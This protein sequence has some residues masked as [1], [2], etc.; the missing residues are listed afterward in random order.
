MLFTALGIAIAYF[1]AFGMDFVGGAIAWRL[2]IAMQIVPAI[3]ISI[4]LLGLPETPRWLIEK[5]RVDEAV[6]VMCK[7]YGTTEDDDYIVMEKR[8]II[9][10]L[11]LERKSPFSWLNV[12]KKDQIQTGK[13]VLLACLGL[14]F[15][16]VRDLQARDFLPI[17]KTNRV[18][19]GLA[20]TW[21][22]FTSPV[23][24]RKMSAS[25]G[26]CLLSAVAASTWPLP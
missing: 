4:M 9:E 10:S 23:F 19:S 16:Q 18:C 6:E 24:W 14:S 26:T 22:Y 12:F 1:F 2:P 3:I 13:R 17:E 11:E 5:G 8:Q 15:N 20:S 21:L 7:V 25:P